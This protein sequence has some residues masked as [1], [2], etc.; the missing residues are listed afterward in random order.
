MTTADC[1]RAQAGRRVYGIFQYGG[2]IGL[3]GRGA[4]ES[5]SSCT[6]TGAARG[7]LGRNERPA[8]RCAAVWFT[9]AAPTSPLVASLPSGSTDRPTDPQPVV[10]WLLHS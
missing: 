3:S 8:A 10:F 7:G 1:D 6:L 9:A 5:N 4:H 2:G